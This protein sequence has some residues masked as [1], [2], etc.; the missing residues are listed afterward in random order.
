LEEG[1]QD[2]PQSKHYLKLIK[3]KKINFNLFV[4]KNNQ[5]GVVN[6]IIHGDQGLINMA[7]QFILVCIISYGQIF[8]SKYFNFQTIL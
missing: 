5:I 6:G 7:N 2:F 8:L 3:I 1:Q 4:M